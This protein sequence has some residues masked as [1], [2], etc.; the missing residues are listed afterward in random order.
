MD[1]IN[2]FIIEGNLTKDPEARCM[3]SGRAVTS[4]TVAVSETFI[5]DDVKREV[6]AYITVTTYGKQA[7]NDARYLRKGSRVTVFGR[8]TSWFKREEGK[9]GY[10]FEAA[11]VIYRGK[12]PA[13]NAQGLPTDEHDQWVGD[14]DGAADRESR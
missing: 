5:Q 11:R 9:G 2:Q 3:P 13:G 1:G 14:Y 7:E 4:F 6:V 8:I 12:A 10:N